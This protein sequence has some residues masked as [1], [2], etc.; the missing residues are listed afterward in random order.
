MGRSKELWGEDASTFDPERFVRD[1]KQANNAFKFTAFQGGPRTCLGQNMAYL[2]EKTM[3][4]MI[5]QRYDIHLIEGQKVEI[6]M[7]ATL[8]MKR[9]LRLQFIP[10]NSRKINFC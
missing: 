7:S 2:E 10:R 8:P 1:P 9:G 3:L 5:F 4:S 6:Q